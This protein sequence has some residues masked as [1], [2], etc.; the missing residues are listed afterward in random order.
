V[1]DAKRQHYV[2]RFLLSRFADEREQVRTVDKQTGKSFPQNM[3]NAAVETHF[4]RI[5]FGDKLPSNQFEQL[6][7]TCEDSAAVVINR[8]LDEDFWTLPDWERATLSMFVAIQAVRTRSVRDD[9][10]HL[11][12]FLHQYLETAEDLSDGL[13]ASLKEDLER[14]ADPVVGDGA[15]QTFQRMHLDVIIDAVQQLI[16]IYTNERQMRLLRFRRQ[17]LMISDHPVAL[18]ADVGEDVGIGNGT[19]EEVW[20]PLSRDTAVVLLPGK[21]QEDGWLPP[22]TRMAQWVNSLVARSGQR[23]LYHHPDDDPTRNLLVDL[24]PRKRREIRMERLV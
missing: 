18:H 4:Y 12:D 21:P 22:S 23:W 2:S 1:V 17:K 24:E 13:R 5:E 3:K 10:S 7:S 20:L 6:L 11:A 19:A 15:A 16:P 8:I 9:M 14:T